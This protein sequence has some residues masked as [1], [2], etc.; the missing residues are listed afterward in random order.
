MNCRVLRRNRPSVELKSMEDKEE[1]PNLVTGNKTIET[2]TKLDSNK[3][4]RFDNTKLLTKKT[5]SEAT[6]LNLKK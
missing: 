2:E 1:R 5:T 4:N 3:R 6:Q